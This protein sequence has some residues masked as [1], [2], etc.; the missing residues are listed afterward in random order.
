[1]IHVVDVGVSFYNKSN[2]G[3]NALQKFKYGVDLIFSDNENKHKNLL[4]I[5]DNDDDYDDDDLL[6]TC[7]PFTVNKNLYDDNN[8]NWQIKK[9][10]HEDDIINSEYYSLINRIM[11]EYILKMLKNL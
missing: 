7:N 5:F 8:N 3:N 2:F 4:H 10:D 6:N 9:N 1:M 11:Y